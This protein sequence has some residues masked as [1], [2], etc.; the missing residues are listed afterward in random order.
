MRVD[1]THFWP[2]DAPYIPLDRVIVEAADQF[3]EGVV[4]DRVGLVA[5][6]HAEYL[7]ILE[8]GETS[9][10]QDI[11]RFFGARPTDRT[12]NRPSSQERPH[13]LFPIGH[14]RVSPETVTTN[15]FT[16]LVSTRRFKG[17]S[18]PSSATGSAENRRQ[19]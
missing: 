5:R 15:L 11:Y 13:S 8:G 18:L 7:L 10:R 4:L 14:I 16:L 1:V 17:F 2:A 12:E 3:D 9:G 19:G 6:K